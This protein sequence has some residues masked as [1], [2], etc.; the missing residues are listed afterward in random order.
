MS[1]DCLFCNIIAG[2]IPSHKVYEDDHIYAFLDI[3]PVSKGHT[4][5]I[6]KEHAAD[7][8]EGSAQA[9][10]ELI[11]TV[12]AVAPGLLEALGASSYNLCMNH[13]ADA[14]QTVFHTHMHFM[15]RYAGIPRTFEH[16]SPSQEELA[17]TAKQIRAKIMPVV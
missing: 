12:R 10:A 13:G 9:A 16:T 15:P 11:K 2:N 7:L 17:E 6:P 8:T 14:G 1:A 5:F 3:G 4:L